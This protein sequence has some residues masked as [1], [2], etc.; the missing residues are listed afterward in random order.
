M[1]VTVSTSRPDWTPLGDF[2]VMTRESP[3]IN[4]TQMSP[5]NP[6]CSLLNENDDTLTFM[7]RTELP[8]KPYGYIKLTGT[9]LT[10]RVWEFRVHSLSLCNL[11]V[12]FVFNQRIFTGLSTVHTENILSLRISIIF[13]STSTLCGRRLQYEKCARRFT[14]GDV[15][16]LRV[17]EQLNAWFWEALE[18][19][20]WHWTFTV[21]WILTEMRIFRKKN[22]KNKKT[23]PRRQHR[24]LQTL[25]SPCAIRA[26]ETRLMIKHT[27][28]SEHGKLINTVIH[29]MSQPTASGRY[30]PI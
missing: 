29:A 15:F 23:N 12:T 30:S 2:G 14:T 10:N 1:T 4:V 24:V 8:S 27:K 17:Q 7:L 21:A 11:N 26:K 18:K 28:S 25:P 19:K 5:K 6:E 13:R 9:F 22:T 3:Y 20:S 16:V